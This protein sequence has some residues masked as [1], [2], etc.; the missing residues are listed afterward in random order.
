MET[1]KPE[2]NAVKPGSGAVLQFGIG[3][4]V[5]GRTRVLANPPVRGY[6]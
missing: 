4:T 1:R 5:R 3:T 6:G 2:V